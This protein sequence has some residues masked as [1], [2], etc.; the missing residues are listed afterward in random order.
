MMKK[1][2]IISLMLWTVS[3]ADGQIFVGGQLGFNSI[4]NGETG[5]TQSVFKVSPGIGIT[6]TKKWSFCFGLTY[7]TKEDEYNKFYISPSMRYTAFGIGDVSF[8]IDTGFDYA[9]GKDKTRE[10]GRQKFSEWNANIKPGIVLN[11]SDRV[12]FVAHIAQIGFRQ[13][14]WEYTKPTNAFGVGVDM[15][16]VDLGLYFSF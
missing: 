8:I 13:E 5:V 1:L 14:K 6:L 7:L 16:D 15:D 9:S 12:W 3:I 10:P 11:F 2:I 4:H